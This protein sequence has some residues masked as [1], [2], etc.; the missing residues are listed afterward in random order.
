MVPDEPAPSRPAKRAAAA[1][2][3]PADV[4]P[5]A[6]SMVL[7]RIGFKPGGSGD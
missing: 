7:G 5:D 6:L 3:G 2:T 4:S 1:M